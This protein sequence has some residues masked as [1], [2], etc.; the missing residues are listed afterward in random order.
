MTSVN[1]HFE[2]Y[3]VPLPPQIL[4]LVYHFGRDRIYSFRVCFFVV[5]LH[6]LAFH[7]YWWRL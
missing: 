6:A 2:M 4:S 5:T 7:L 1:I 3:Y